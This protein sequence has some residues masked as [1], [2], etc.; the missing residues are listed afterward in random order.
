MGYKGRLL[1]FVIKNLY[2]QAIIII[3]Y[4]HEYLSICC[5]YAP[6]LFGIIAHNENTIHQK[7]IRH[8]ISILGDLHGCFC[9]EVLGSLF[10][11]G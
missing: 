5:R 3:L 11:L 6:P 9:H 1:D 8:F 10:V 7:R 2:V 4:L